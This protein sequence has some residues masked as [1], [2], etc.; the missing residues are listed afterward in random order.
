MT[1]TEKNNAHSANAG[2][3]TNKN[4]MC[5]YNILTTESNTETPPESP[6]TKD[7]EHIND[8][9]FT[10]Q[11]VTQQTEA[12]PPE[13]WES[14]DPFQTVIDTLIAGGLCKLQE[15]YGIKAASNTYIDNIHSAINKFIQDKEKT[16][17]DIN[18]FIESNS[19]N[20]EFWFNFMQE[21]HF[22]KLAA[23]IYSNFYSHIGPCHRSTTKS[24]SEI[25]S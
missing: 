4:S 18:S 13:F 22:E 3:H 21:L 16:L 12:T 1:D 5:K 17:K 8:P 25:L 23:K 20:R 14:L 11:A 2:K 10:L 9:Q 6:Q 19:N 7:F 15:L 24:L